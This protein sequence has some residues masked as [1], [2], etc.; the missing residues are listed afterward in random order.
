MSQLLKK[1]KKKIDMGVG[2]N[3]LLMLIYI[4]LYGILSRIL[5]FVKIIKPRPNALEALW[6]KGSIDC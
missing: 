3:C 2:R 6:C 4:F 5:I 1:K